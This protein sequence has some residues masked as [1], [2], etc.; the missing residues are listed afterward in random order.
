MAESAT[1]PSESESRPTMET[2]RLL[3]RPTSM[4]DAADFRRYIYSWDICDSTPFPYPYVDGAAETYL[5]KHPSDYRD[6]IKAVFSVELK[7]DPGHVIGMTVIKWDDEHKDIGEVHGVRSGE[8][9]LGS[10]F[11]HG[12][13]QQDAEVGI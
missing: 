7:S 3:I 1:V 5:S 10:R 2:G 6:K 11:S 8:T 4:D 12:S 13:H 9:F